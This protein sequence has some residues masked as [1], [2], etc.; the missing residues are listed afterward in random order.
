MILT[1]FFASVGKSTNS[2]ES[3]AEEHNFLLHEN[4]FTPKSF[5]TS[6]Q[7]T[8]NYVDCKQVADVI[9]AMPSNRAPGIDKV[10]TRVIKDSLLIILHVNHQCFSFSFNQEGGGGGGGGGTEKRCCHN[11]QSGHPAWWSADN[12]SIFPT[13]NIFRLFRSKKRTGRG[14]QKCLKN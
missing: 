6:E 14:N 2:N 1:T 12:C 4:A 7:F 3:L 8:L 5:R 10:L 9:N 13:V 11:L